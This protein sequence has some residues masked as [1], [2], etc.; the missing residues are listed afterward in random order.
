MLKYPFSHL[1]AAAVVV[2]SVV[3]GPLAPT[4]A[5]ASGTTFA[6]Q[7]CSATSN[8]TLAHGGHNIT[9]LVS[10]GDVFTLVK[11]AGAFQEPILTPLPG[12]VSIAIPASY[13]VPTGISS[14]RFL[15]GSGAGDGSINITC[16]TTGGADLPTTAGSIGANSQTTATRTGISNNTQ[17]RLG[18]GSGNSA[19][20]NSVFMSTQN[21]PGAQSQFGQPDWNAWISVEGRSYSGDFEG[22]TGDVVA[23]IDTLISNDLIVGA[24]L[25]YGRV[26]IQ[27]PTQRAQITSV[28][29]GAYFA[30]RFQSDLFL[31]GFISLARPDYQTQGTTFTSSRTSAS[32]TLTGSYTGGAWN[33]TPFG[34]FGAYREQQPA[35]VG[36]GGAVAANDITNISLALG[37]KVEPLAPLASGLLPYISLGVD[38]GANTS[39][40]SGTSTFISPRIGVG[41]GMDLSRGYLSVDL[42]AGKV[43]EGVRDLGLRATYEFSF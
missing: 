38:Y 24:L 43:Q 27:S 11:G 41:F 35:Y 30:K 10:E 14:V 17:N 15:S 12:G 21:L 19:T 32:L 23:G 37:A 6:A 33:V 42:D 8:Y 16:A 7:T 39:T 28:A 18:G 4:A 1:C 29:L 20:R 25:A 13:T 31:D 34:K 5:Y 9:I 2:S 40:I 36:T 22:W 26:D 3:A